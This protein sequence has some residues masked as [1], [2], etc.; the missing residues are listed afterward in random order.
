MAGLLVAGAA[1]GVGQNERHATEGT[2][3]WGWH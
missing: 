2:D 3:P 1:V